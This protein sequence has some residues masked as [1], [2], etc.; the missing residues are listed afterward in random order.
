[1]IEL[2]PNH[3]YGLALP[4]PVMPA[5][6][7]FGYAT[8]YADLVEIGLLGAIVTN[9]LSLRPRQAVTGRRI[10]V[11]GDHVVVHTGLSNPGL[12]AV[13]RD[14]ARLWEHLPIPVIVHVSATTPEEASRLSRELA[15]VG[16][17]RGIELGLAEGTRA[18]RALEL[19]Q[20]AR[21]GGL[22]VIV[23]VPFSR[24]DELTPAL[25]RNEVDAL[26]LTAPPRA[27]LPMVTGPDEQV[28]RFMRGRLYGPA[29][30]ALLLNTL[31]RWVPKLGVPVI[32]CGGIAS[33]EDALACLSLGAAAVQIDAAL[34]RDPAL[35]N[36]I[37]R[38][39]SEPVVP[40]SDAALPT[41]EE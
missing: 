20:A 2:A 39:L 40:A 10:A 28:A 6:G 12:R 37:A 16:A 29:L 32:A 21:D 36:R 41:E 18:R 15:A 31:A 22:P 3:K 30:F 34:W 26:T 9:P 33:A 24:V 25:A 23:R 14:Y 38:G 27:V 8:E 4:A 35:L 7:T 5:S 1:M 17:V 11:H 13:V 19:L